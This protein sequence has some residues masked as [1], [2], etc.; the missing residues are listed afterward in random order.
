[1]VTKVAKVTGIMAVATWTTA[2]VIWV[3]KGI[4]GIMAERIDL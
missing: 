3:T 1:M 2:T 4:W